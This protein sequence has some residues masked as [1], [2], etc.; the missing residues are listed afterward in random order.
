MHEVKKEESEF[1]SVSSVRLRWL[2]GCLWLL[3]ASLHSTIPINS[4]SASRV[5]YGVVM[6]QRYPYPNSTWYYVMTFDLTAKYQYPTIIILPSSCVTRGEERFVA[7]P[8]FNINPLNRS[9]DMNHTFHLNS[10]VP[11]PSSNGTVDNIR[12][13]VPEVLTQPHTM[14]ELFVEVT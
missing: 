2:I 11:D 7:P 3:A 8:T 4:Y 12:L 13:S 6:D 5:H 10:C 9:I 1:N 14:F